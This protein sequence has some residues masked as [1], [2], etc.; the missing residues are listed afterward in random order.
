MVSF[1]DLSSCPFFFFTLNFPRQVKTCY[2]T[3]F[4]VT[5]APSYSHPNVN[6]IYCVSIIRNNCYLLCLV[7]FYL[8]RS[9]FPAVIPGE[10]LVS[11][12][13]RCFLPGSVLVLPAALLALCLSW[14]Q[15]SGG[16]TTKPILRCFALIFSVCFSMNFLL[17]P[18]GER[19]CL[20]FYLPKLIIVGLLWLSAVT[21]GIWQT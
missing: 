10:Q 12:D 4:T 9:I 15:G 5:D 11:R 2:V 19:K 21:L 20:T 14:H 6:C 16:S 18:Q 7:S 3:F 1:S 13:L 8:F 17:S